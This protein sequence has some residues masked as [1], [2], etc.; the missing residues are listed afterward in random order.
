MPMKRTRD[1]QPAAPS[2][3]EQ[4]NLPAE[5]ATLLSDNAQDRNPIESAAANEIP[6]PA[7]E[8][9]YLYHWGINE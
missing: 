2:E 1:P 9:H 8:S 7:E 5:P 3:T 4:P 6:E